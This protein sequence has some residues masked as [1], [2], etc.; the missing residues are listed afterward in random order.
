MRTILNFDD[1]L[2]AAPALPQAVTARA[3][4]VR[5]PAGLFQSATA[6]ADA[7]WGRW[8]GALLT[9]TV[10]HLVAVAVGL[11]VSTRPPPEVKKPEPELVLMA[12]APPPP[13]LGGGM[14]KQAAVEPVKPVVQKPRPKRQELVVPAKVPEPVKETPVEQVEETPPA[15]EVASVAPQAPAGPG[16]PDGAV[17][18]VVGGVV[19]G[20][21]GG[22]AGG[23]GTAPPIYT[24]R[25][26]MKLP[27]LLSGKPE[28]PRRAREDGI[29]GVVMVMVVIGT[30][31]AVEP[32]SPRIH[33]SVPGLDEAA[34][35]SVA[36]WRF[37]PA[38]G[39]DG[40]PV[41]VKVVIPVK[42]ALR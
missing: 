16:V 34:L 40:A 35:E 27:V 9:A 2:G 29:T 1:G 17:G 19:G 36:S 22:K 23:Q 21:V 26:V 31:G 4:V 11:L 33:R 32:G 39:H 15:T 7:G 42:F 30:D 10:A 41:R 25:E 20:I 28:Y 18:G 38:L 24:P 13:P 12:Y 6:P 5:V 8:S 37:S 3:D 14:R